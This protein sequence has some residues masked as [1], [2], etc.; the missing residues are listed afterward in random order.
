M[1]DLG[2]ILITGQSIGDHLDSWMGKPIIDFNE[3]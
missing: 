1:T 2:V 3:A